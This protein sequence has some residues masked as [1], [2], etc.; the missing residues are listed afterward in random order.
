M[1][2]EVR[3]VLSWVT[4]H[5]D[6]DSGKRKFKS[7]MEFNEFTLQ[8]LIL[9][10]VSDLL[11]DVY[12]NVESSKELWDS[13]EAKY[14]AE[15]ASSKK[16]LD[17]D[18]PKGNNVSGPS[19]VNMMEH[20]NFIRY[21]D[22]KG[23][24]KH[25][26]TK[27]D[28]NKKSKVTCW[29]CGKPRHL[30]KDCKGVKVGNKANGSGTNGSSNSLKGQN[31][32]NKS[33]QVYYVTYV[34]EAYFMLDDDVAWWVDSGVT[35]H[36]CKDRCWFKTRESLNDGSILHMGNESTTMVHRRDSVDLIFSSRKIVS[37]FND[38]HVP[39]IRK[40]LV[41][42]SILNNCGYKQVIESNKFILSK[43]GVFIG[44]GYLYNHMFKLNIVNDNIGSAFMSTSKLNDSIRWHA[45]LGHVHFKRMQE[46]S[47]DGLI[48][49]FDM[50]TKK[51]KT[52]MLTK[53]TKKPFQNVK[54]KTKVLEPIH[55]NLCDLHATPS[56]RNKKYSVS[57]I[58]DAS[59][60]VV[61]LLDPKLKTL[62]ERGIECIFV[63]YAEHSKTF[64]FYVIEPNES[65]SINLIIKS[66]DLIFDKNRFS[67]VPKPS[68]RSLINGTE[69]IGGSV[70]LEEVTEEVVVQQ[71]K[72]ELRKSKRNR[73]P[74]NFGPEFQLYLIEGTRDEVSDQHSYCFNV[75]DDP[76]TFDEAMKSHDLAFWKEAIND[77]VDSIM[78][79]NTWV[80]AHLPPSC[81]PLG[82]KWIFKRKLK[83]D[84]TIEKFKARLYNKIVD[85]I[86]INSQSDYSSNGCEDNIL[87]CKFNESGK[88]VIICLYVDDML[89]FGTDKVKV[90]SQLKY[91]RVIGCLM[92][93]MTCT[94]PNIAF[95]VGKLILE[96]YTDASWIS[97]TEDNSSTSGWVFLL[98]E[99]A[100]SWASK[101]QTC[102]TSSTMES[103]FVALAAAGKEAEW[104][105][106]LILKISLWSKP[107]EPISIRC[108]SDATLAK[109]YSQMYNGKSRYLGVRHSMIR[110]LIMNG[111]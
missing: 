76:K 59:R 103:E 6:S 23:K 58:D 73:I 64:R 71:P 39:N 87:E 52:C 40:N 22:D 84:G 44:F 108:D 32:F 14:M 65:V 68:H 98:G 16:F 36:V 89:I 25:Q 4:E 57:F 62:G 55:S 29:K 79:N 34:S 13:L 12:Q 27:T 85:Y 78:G 33:L 105:R 102:I 21:N 48:L 97:N 49:A 51:C 100:I 110:E 86:G 1:R 96:G 95:V 30:K 56:L 88:G 106:N 101:K 8:G 42:S 75:E 31:M 83:L 53:I 43:H 92:Y 63:G 50:D 24:R 17:S 69:D 67:S 47:K 18:K 91:S 19:V 20:N 54:R 111:V 82:C 70:V 60:A 26:D 109:A 11:F 9:N 74:K 104:L 61:K 7:L 99:G 81:K 45:R 80:L 2:L 46:L 41:S 93:A 37:L 107:I 77:E 28:P 5:P 10:G 38:L 35:V 3:S 90:V 94:R 72:P 66:R 15:N